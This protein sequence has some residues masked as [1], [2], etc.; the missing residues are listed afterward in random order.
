M[1]LQWKHVLIKKIPV[2][3]IQDFHHA[4]IIMPI[5]FAVSIGIAYRRALSADC[6]AESHVLD[7]RAPVNAA[8]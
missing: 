1:D 2:Y 3:S 8:L 4:M 7:V 5:A 6:R